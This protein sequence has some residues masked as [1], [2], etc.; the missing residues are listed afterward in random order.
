LQK[1]IHGGTRATSH[2]FDVFLMYAAKAQADYLNNEY[3]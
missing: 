2:I 3:F 1:N